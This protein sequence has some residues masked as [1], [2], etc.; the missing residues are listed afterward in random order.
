M[1]KKIFIVLFAL[2]LLAL[3]FVAGQNGKTQRVKDTVGHYRHLLRE[4]DYTSK[5]PIHDNSII[6]W[7]HVSED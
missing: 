5:I 1:K 2:A 6:Q 7:L 3:G 4:W